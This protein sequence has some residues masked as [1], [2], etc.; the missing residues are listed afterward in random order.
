NSLKKWFTKRLA[1]ITGKIDCKEDD[2]PPSFLRT[3][4]N[5]K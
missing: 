3:Y 1:N 4:G 5:A 2:L